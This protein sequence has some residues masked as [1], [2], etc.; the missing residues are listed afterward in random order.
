MSMQNWTEYGFGVHLFTGNNDEKV[1]RFIEK[2]RPD[3]VMPYCEF[4]EYLKEDDASTIFYDC[5]GEPASQIISYIINDLE[6]ITVFS[7]Y[8]P[9]GDTDQEEMIGICPT[10][11]WKMNEK[12]KNLT[13]QD[14]FNLL[15]KYARIL[16][17]DDVYPDYFAAE[18]CG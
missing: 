10:Y 6:G 1:Y 13:Q 5:N 4:V 12:D 17:I 15:N 3:S 2:Y 11:T 18:Y 16:G 7:G 8:W 9:C 14:A